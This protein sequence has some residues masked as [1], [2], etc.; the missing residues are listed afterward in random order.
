MAPCT[1]A[2]IVLLS[3]FLHVVQR[4]EGS[5]TQAASH[6]NETLHLAGEP[7]VYGGREHLSRKGELSSS[8][9]LDDSPES[10]LLVRRSEEQQDRAPLEATFPP[11]P[12]PPEPGKRAY[13]GRWRDR[14]PIDNGLMIPYPEPR[15]KTRLILF[16]KLYNALNETSQMCQEGYPTRQLQK[17]VVVQAVKRDGVTSTTRYALFWGLNNYARVPLDTAECSHER[18]PVKRHA[19]RISPGDLGDQTTLENLWWFRA[20]DP[21]GIKSLRYQG[22]YNYYTSKR[23]K[24]SIYYWVIALPPPEDRV[25]DSKL[26]KYFRI[27]K[28]SVGLPEVPQPG[29]RKRPN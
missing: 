28:H 5:T 20:N 14:T 6:D 15:L 26:E 29:K 27:W 21:D 10:N 3:I 24:Y 22:V 25:P 13:P 2:I 4:C 17:I 23:E 18:L 1:K 12:L 8:L 16:Q 19:F 9:P 7:D 11:P